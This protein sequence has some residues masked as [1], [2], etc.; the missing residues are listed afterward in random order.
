MRSNSPLYFMVDGHKV[1]LK[2]GLADF[3]QFGV[4]VRVEAEAFTYDWVLKMN[5]KLSM[6]K[7][8][9]AGA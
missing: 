5:A 2:D 9:R 4:L 8:L 1:F 6:I 3:T 7:N